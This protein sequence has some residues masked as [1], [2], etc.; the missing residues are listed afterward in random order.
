M[1]CAIHSS[2]SSS[3]GICHES[4]L[5]VFT[6]NSVEMLGEMVGNPP[7]LGVLA[8]FMSTSI[9]AGVEGK[10]VRRR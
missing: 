8:S 9:I 4:I 1:V 7:N 2:L 5:H 6:I 10:V 3:S